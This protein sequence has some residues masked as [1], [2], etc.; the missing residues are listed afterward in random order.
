MVDEGTIVP[1]RK[2]AWS[3]DGPAAAKASVDEWFPSIYDCLHDLAERRFRHEPLGHTF[4]PTA[5]VHEA[6][7]RLV[8]GRNRRWRDRTHLFAVAARTLREV[9]VDH[10][11]RKATIKR[12]RGC[13]RVVLE[14]ADQAVDARTVDLLMLDESLTR[15]AANHER[16]GRVVEL[17][18]FAGLT[19]EET[20]EVLGVSPTTVKSDWQFARAWLR[21]ELEGRTL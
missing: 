11:R 8:S 6:Y 18:Y 14:V 1:G 21:R 15:F 9:L 4:Q 12:G 19:V 2:A 17:R 13:G 16:A 10:A 20:A 5:L 7:V 3:G